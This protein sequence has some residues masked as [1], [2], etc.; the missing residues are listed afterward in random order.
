[1]MEIPGHSFTAGERT[2]LGL[3]Q[4]KAR[5]EGLQ[6]KANDV[7]NREGR[8]NRW[9]QT[10]ERIESGEA[11]NRNMIAFVRKFFTY[12]EGKMLQRCYE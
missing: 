4:Q 12:N 5:R 8:A 2:K 3:Q 11:L 9:P 10:K 7:K 1:M 6:N